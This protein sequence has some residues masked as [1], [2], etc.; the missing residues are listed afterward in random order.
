MNEAPR[1]GGATGGRPTPYGLVFGGGTFDEARFEPLRAQAESYGANRPSELLLLPAAGELLRELLPE[2]TP[3]IA[4]GDL[5]AQ[6][7]ALLF[8]A[9]RFWLHGQP[10]Y[11]LDEA[12]LRPALESGTAPAGW[13]FRTPAPAG[14]VQLPHHVLWA[15]VVE[16]SAAEPA[17]GFFW[18]AGISTG[19]TAPHLDLLLVLGLRPG[20]PGI[21]LVEV[22]AEGEPAL[23]QWAR[24]RARPDGPDF[25]NIL[26]GGELQA[27]HGLSTQAEVLKLAVLSFLLIDEAGATA[28]ADEPESGVRR[29]RVH[30]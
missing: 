25:G 10:V 2:D 28:A 8:H 21:S 29:Y 20:R 5:V 15:R 30:G 26:P 1:H 13:T 17:D 7:G 27:Y 24:V 12:L 16:G 18:S 19:A 6:T 11:E 4:H 23:A 22:A 9:F 3:E 14:Y